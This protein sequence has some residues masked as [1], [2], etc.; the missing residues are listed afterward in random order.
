MAVQTGTASYLERRWLNMPVRDL[1]FSASGASAPSD[2][3]FEYNTLLLN[4]DGTNGAQ[5]NTFLDSSTNNFTITR[6]GNTTQGSFSPYGSNWSNY[7]GAGTTNYLTSGTSV[8]LTGSFT[9]E[10]WVNVT[11]SSVN[12]IGCIGDEFGSTGM[13]FFI[14]ASGN[15]RIYTN[16]AYINNITGTTIP[17]NTWTHIAFVRNSG[18]ITTYV[19]G[20]SVNT[21]SH[22]ATLSGVVYVGNE[23][24]NGTNSP[25]YFGYASNVR[26]TNTAVYTGT[27]TP[28]TTPLT[29]ISGTQLLTCQSNRFIDNSTN[30]ATITPTGTPS[31]QRFSPFNPTAPYS[32]SVIGGSGYFDGSG[33]YLTT[34]NVTALNIYNTTNTVECWFFP[35]SFST[36]TQIY[37]SNFDGTDYNRWRLTDTNGYPDY[38]SRFGT[39]ITGST[40]ARLNQW[41]HIAFGRSGST[42]SIWLNGVRVAN[43]TILVESAWGTGNIIVGGFE[44]SGRANGYMSNLRVVKGTDV[45]GVSNTTITV[46]TSPVTAIAN[47]AFLLNSTNAGIP[48]LAMQNN[49]ETVGNAQVSTSVKKYGTGSLAFDGTGDLLTF[50]TST[51]ALGSGAYTIEFWIYPTSLPSGGGHVIAANANNGLVVV[52]ST[53]KTALNKFGVGDVVAYN[54]ALSTNTWTHVAIVRE[55]TGTNQTKIYINGT[56]QATGTDNNTWTVTTSSAIG[57]NSSSSS[58][59][60]TGYLDDFRITYGLARYTANFTAPTSALPTF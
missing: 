35:L 34:P 44:T 10:T 6:N 19:N 17:T 37:G 54:T 12:V 1:L 29:A 43:A 58:Q 3:N 2:P 5:N 50:P 15:I 59:Y 53:T 20:T 41:N 24:Y 8:S 55:G 25:S 14:N 21:V 60:I 40:G 56:S 30:N 28:S 38:L 7:I 27:F 39:Q 31:V 11:T 9:Y 47:T 26:L 22:S 52:I 36:D 16:N 4:G 49:L 23:R 42:M 32:T 33:D 57:G 45:Y 13:C 18:T 46:P 51:M 48:D